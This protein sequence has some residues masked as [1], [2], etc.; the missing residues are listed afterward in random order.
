MRWLALC[1]T[2]ESPDGDVDALG[3]LALSFTP[4]VARL[5][6]AVV[7][8]VSTSLK[9]FRGA[10]ALRQRRRTRTMTP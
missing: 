1:C 5:E 8:E 9:L 6:E 10:R 4:R 7:A 2:P 3:W